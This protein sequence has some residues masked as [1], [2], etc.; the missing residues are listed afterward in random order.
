MLVVSSV[1]P[2]SLPYVVLFPENV[3]ERGYV[4]VL[5][6][7]AV[8]PGSI[9]HLLI[10]SMPV[11]WLGWCIE[12]VFGRTRYLALLVGGAFGAG[13]AYVLSQPLY[14]LTGGL[15]A[16]SAVVVAFVFWSVPNRGRFGV[17]LRMFW[18]LAV[19]WVAYTVWASPLEF[20]AV[21]MVSWGVGALVA[22]SWVQRRQSMP[23][24]TMEPTR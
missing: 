15:F 19:I 23:N 14:P 11:L 5:L 20:A 1:V 8:L 24:N 21:H 10:V 13:I 18:A 22:F 7:Y 9:L 4:W 2:A 17:P 16:A 12:P 3:T 6:T